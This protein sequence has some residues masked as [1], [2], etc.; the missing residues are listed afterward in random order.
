MVGHT[1]HKI[2]I[3]EY[4]TQMYEQYISLS[5]HR[6]GYNFLLPISIS[7][8]KIVGVCYIF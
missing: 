5:K 4:R 8:Q 6:N 7:M 1:G 2:T 3:R